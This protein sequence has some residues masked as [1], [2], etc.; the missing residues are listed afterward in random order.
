[1]AHRDFRD[2]LAVL[3]QSGKL[4]RVAQPVDRLWQPASLAKWMFQAIL[5]D[6]RF[7]LFF[8]KVEGSDFRLTTGAIGASR[9]TYA[10]ALGV[11]PDE[12]GEAWRV[13]LDHPVPPRVVETGVCQEVV[14][15]GDAVDLDR[16][17]IPVWTP[18]KDAGPYITTIVVNRHRAMDYQ[19]MGVYRTQVRD[20][21]SVIVNLSP[22]RQGFACAMSYLERGEPAPIA[23]VIGAEPV[24]HVASVANMPAG[25]DEITV[26]GGLKREPVE[27]VKCRTSDLLVPAN[28]E[29]VIEGEV[30]PGEWAQEGP[31]GEFAGYMGP[32]SDKPV[33]RIRAITHR[34]DAIYYGLTSQMPPSES[35]TMQSWSNGPVLLK[36]LHD[37]GETGIRDI[38]IDLTFG[39][40]LAHGVV[41]MTPR[42]PA[43]PKRIGRLIAAMS[44]LKRITLVDADVD[45]RDPLHVEWAL[46]AHYNPVRDTE[47][48]D[49]VYF[50]MHMDP[51]VR[52]TNSET[53]LGSKIIVDATRT[54]DAGAYSLPP[55]EIMDKA[56]DLWRE[57]GLPEFEI[58]KRARNLID[59]S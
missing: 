39:G 36:Q 41:A 26:A 16:L 29:M 6:D 22:G 35:T 27:M 1:M 11:T 30:M 17:P 43:D 18:G 54:I 44:P 7:G 45:P 50:P 21:R 25:Y 14:H 19:N 38:H 12:I 23:W 51:S 3:E 58:P 55:K 47:I 52:I 56:L 53:E 46:N 31:F 33:A 13:A 2:F 15:L 8:E 4:R 34:T 49:D 24:V 59:K 5:E 9:H 40:I 57:V 32:V 48:V 10:M 28:A 42:R 37:M 20:K